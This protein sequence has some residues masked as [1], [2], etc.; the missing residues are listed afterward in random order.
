MSNLKWS[1]NISDQFL[2]DLSN[3]ESA[4]EQVVQTDDVIDDV[5]DD[6]TDSTADGKKNIAAP[7]KTMLA[8]GYRCVHCFNSCVEPSTCNTSR[9]LFRNH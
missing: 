1:W 5:T 8:Y 9:A 2:A 3:R 6:V 7:T 4:M